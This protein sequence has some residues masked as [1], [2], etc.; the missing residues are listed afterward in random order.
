LTKLLVYTAVIGKPD[1]FFDPKPGLPDTDKV[2]FTDMEFQGRNK[3]QIVKVDPV[4]THFGKIQRH[5]KIF[6]FPEYWDKYDY[7]L[8]LD[9]NV[10]LLV[11]PAVFID[12]LGDNDLL[13][14]KH[15][16]RD[17]LYDEA[18][19]CLKKELGSPDRIRAQVKKYRGEGY[20]ERNGLFR[21]T[22]LFRRHTPRMKG[23]SRLWWNEVNEF[24]YRDQISFPYVVWKTD[25]PV[26]TF[27]VMW[28]DNPWFRGYPHGPD[29]RFVLREPL[30]CLDLG[31]GLHKKP[32]CL[33]V[34]RTYLPGVD[35]VHDLEETPWPFKDGQ[36]EALY[37]THLL[38]HIANLIPF[39]NEAHRILKPGGK[40]EIYVPLA[41]D[42]DGGIH[43]GAF[44]DPTHVRFFVK[45]SFSYFTGRAETVP[46]GILP[47]VLEH[48]EERTRGGNMEAVAVLKK[49]KLSADFW[50]FIGYGASR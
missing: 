31:C 47:W 39:M 1:T 20:P 21:C 25:F 50:R 23:F 24:C 5:I 4:G 8:Y 43:P 16:F 18:E 33:G 49:P 36:F 6:P 15:E 11:D 13:L 34:D 48:Y 22:V 10:Q 40:F 27:D 29:N 41:I 19:A 44:Q 32:N 3:Y 7:S 38:E 42:V 45:E 17:C 35:Y 14:F 12:M 9:S 28:P 26:S 2:C 37:A 46:Y 30:E